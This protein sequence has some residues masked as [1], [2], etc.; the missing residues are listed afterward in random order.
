MGFL[1]GMEPRE[2]DDPGRQ[3]GPE[4]PSCQLPAQNVRQCGLIPGADGEQIKLAC[5]NDP[6]QCPHSNQKG[7]SNPLLLPECLQVKAIQLH[8]FIFFRYLILL[9]LSMAKE[10]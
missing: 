5:K 3:S 10:P 7:K 6:D 9:K 2:P 8:W 1:D 4:T